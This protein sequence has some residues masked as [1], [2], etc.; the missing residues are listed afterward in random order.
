MWCGPIACVKSQWSLTLYSFYILSASSFVWILSDQGC[1]GALSYATS[2]FCFSI[3]YFA[4][5]FYCLPFISSLFMEPG[6][7]A[8]TGFDSRSFLFQ[9]VHNTLDGPYS[10]TTPYS[11]YKAPAPVYSTLNKLN[12]WTSSYSYEGWIKAMMLPNWKSFQGQ[13]WCPF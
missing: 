10:I 11:H 1:F 3:I 4:F 6:L 13:F 7:A 12:C 5:W 9:I 8:C 2:C